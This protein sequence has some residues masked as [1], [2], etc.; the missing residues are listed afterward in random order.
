MSSGPVITVEHLGK[1]YRIGRAVHRP[2]NLREALTRLPLAPF[3]YLTTHLRHLISDSRISHPAS[4]IPLAAAELPSGAGNP[5]SRIP[6][7]PDILWALKDISFEVQQGEVL[8]IIGRNG[9]GKSTLLKILS[10][11]TDPTEGRAV[12]HGRVNAL[13]EVGTGFHQELTGRENIYMSAALHGMKRAEINRK[14]E[15]IVDFAGI[16]KFIDTPVKRYS[17][18]MYTRLAFS[19][20]A[21]LEPDVLIVDEVLA[22]GD[23]EFQRKCLGKMEDVAREGRTVLFVSHQME[24]VSKMCSRCMLL[25]NGRI[26]ATGLTGEIIERY[27]QE[28][29]SAEV[30]PLRTRKDRG[31]AGRLRFTDTWVENERGERVDWVTMGQS[32]KIIATYEVSPGERVR[33]M[34]VGFG[35]NTV[36]NVAIT[37]LANL[38]S[39]DYFE[40]EAPRRGRVECFIPRL[41]LNRGVY[42]YNVIARTTGLEVEDY[43]I[44]AGRFNVEAGDFF[45]TGRIPDS[46]RLIMME[47]KWKLSAEETMAS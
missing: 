18:G 28:A 45:G 23:V 35:L 43:V 36:R 44:H 27:V 6:E 40:G 1:R 34:L 13:L 3:R 2:K 9:A 16:E 14:F 17:S 33:D 46:Q 15:E 31:G 25:K 11:I 26:A 20:A 12:I 30:E 21:H 8:G 39:G 32:M 19:V 47:Q 42:T 5:E 4:R 38:Y 7:S 10:R 41:P 24:A 22:V 29:E 37:D